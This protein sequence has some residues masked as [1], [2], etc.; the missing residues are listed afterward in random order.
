MAE[1]DTSGTYT[2]VPRDKSVIH[3]AI[4][5]NSKAKGV[6]GKTENWLISPIIISSLSSS[7]GNG[8]VMNQSLS[9][10]KGEGNLMLLKIK[11]PGLAPIEP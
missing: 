1:D 7:L 10:Q 3:L 4:C 5:M 9:F 11:N 2:W 8:D 6:P